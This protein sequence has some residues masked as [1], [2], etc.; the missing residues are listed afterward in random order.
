M[1]KKAQ[2]KTTYI[3]YS[4]SYVKKH[5]CVYVWAHAEMYTHISLHKG[6]R[7]GQETHQM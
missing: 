2:A 1:K 6:K 5:V 7:E 4:L 3:Y